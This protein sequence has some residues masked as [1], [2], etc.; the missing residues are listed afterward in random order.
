MIHSQDSGFVPDVGPLV[1]N[2]DGRYVHAGKMSV[3]AAWTYDSAM[4]REREILIAER[5][6]KLFWDHILGGREG[7]L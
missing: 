4:N 1:K 6:V 5:T 7:E 2:L 3:E